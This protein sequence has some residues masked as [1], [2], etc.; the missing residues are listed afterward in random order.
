M[1]MYEQSLTMFQMGISRRPA[2]NRAIYP[3]RDYCN[4]DS[5]CVG[6]SQEGDSG[7]GDAV[8]AV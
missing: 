2:R 1:L 5:E 4:A 7:T 6:V 3:E 8:F